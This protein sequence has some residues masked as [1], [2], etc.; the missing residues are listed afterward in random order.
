MPQLAG[1]LKTF[2]EIRPTGIDSI[3][4]LQELLVKV[5]HILDIGDIGRVEMAHGHRAFFSFL[6]ERV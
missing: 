3:W 1:H 4:V 5:L 6:E 2:E